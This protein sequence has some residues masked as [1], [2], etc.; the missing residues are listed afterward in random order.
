MLISRDKIQTRSKYEIEYVVC[1]G[2]NRDEIYMFKLPN[3]LLIT[4][5]D[6]L[7]YMIYGKDSYKNWKKVDNFSKKYKLIGTYNVEI[8]VKYFSI[9]DI[10]TQLPDSVL[11]EDFDA[12][13]I[14]FE[15]KK[16]TVYRKINEVKENRINSKELYEKAKQ[17]T[18]LLKLNGYEYT[19]QGNYIDFASFS[20]MQIED[21]FRKYGKITHKQ[22]IYGVSYY[23]KALDDYYKNINNFTLLSLLMQVEKSIFDNYSKIIIISPYEYEKNNTVKYKHEHEDGFLVYEYIFE[24]YKSSQFR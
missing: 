14:C 5:Y 3:P 18:F 10:I 4:D 9:D 1:K 20:N 6:F 22:W 23:E 8:F 21:L 15:E 16:V 2:N 12:I 7:N 17:I 24:N 13:N 19:L 11:Y